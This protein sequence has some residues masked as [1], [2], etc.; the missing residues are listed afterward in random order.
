MLKKALEES[1]HEIVR[2]HEILCTN[3]GV[4]EGQPVQLIMPHS[5]VF[6]KISDLQQL[7]TGNGIDSASH[8]IDDNSNHNGGWN[9]IFA[10]AVGARRRANRSRELHL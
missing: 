5:K 2:R 9:A 1:F 6:L 3:F 7:S 4:Q 10:D 8:G